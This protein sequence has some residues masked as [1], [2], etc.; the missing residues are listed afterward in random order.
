LINELISHLDKD[1]DDLDSSIEDIHWKTVE[2]HVPIK[3]QDRKWITVGQ[4]TSL[5]SGRPRD[6]H[7]DTESN[8]S[9][10]V[11]KRRKFISADSTDISVAAKPHSGPHRMMPPSTYSKTPDSL[12]YYLP[13]SEQSSVD[14]MHGMFYIYTIYFDC[15]SNV[16]ILNIGIKKYF[17]YFTVTV[18]WSY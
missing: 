6:S 18:L 4:A 1:S 11:L 5:H 2:S 12:S 3:S 7:Y 15:L 13:S 14:D 9:S 10:P 17:F 16:D 8:T